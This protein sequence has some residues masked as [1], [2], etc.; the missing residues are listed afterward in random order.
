L[1]CPF[2]HARSGVDAGTAPWLDDIDAR[3]LEHLKHP[4]PQTI[5][6]DILA[7]ELQIEPDAG[8]K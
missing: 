8:G 2:R 4:F 3:T 7:A 5:L 1:I 6:T